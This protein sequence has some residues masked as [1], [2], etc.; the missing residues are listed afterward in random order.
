MENHFGLPI[1][2]SDHTEGHAVA[3]AAV[4]LGACIV[5]KHITLDRNLPGPD[6]AASIEP[7]NY[8]A[9]VQGIRAIESA[10]GDG[11]KN[12]TASEHSTRQVAR[13]SLVVA[14]NREAGDRIT[15]ESIVCRR[16]GA[17][18][19]PAQLTSLLGRRFRRQMH[20]GD[21]LSPGDID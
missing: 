8:T 18:I 5:E 3:F 9:Y 13:K 6:H 14:V 19:P 17:G 4:A 2:F 12:P 7:E 11:V 21:L 1:G 10:L 20:A 15:L 16:P